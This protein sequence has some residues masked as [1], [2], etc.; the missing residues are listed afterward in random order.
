MRANSPSWA[1]TRLWIQCPWVWLPSICWDQTSPHALVPVPL[2]PRATL[3]SLFVLPRIPWLSQNG[4]GVSPCSLAWSRWVG[5]HWAL[6]LYC[7]S[8]TWWRYWTRTRREVHIAPSSP[9]VSQ[10]HW[11]PLCPLVCGYW[12]LFWSGLQTHLHSLRR[13]P[14]VVLMVISS[15]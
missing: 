14:L 10:F 9:Y 3:Q 6:E 4:S 5:Y 8:T 11:S 1:G 13:S 2:G 12:A 15:E 7:W